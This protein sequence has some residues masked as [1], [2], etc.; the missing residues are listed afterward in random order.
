MS[1][2]FVR[3]MRQLQNGMMRVTGEFFDLNV[4]SL[5]AFVW[6]FYWRWAAG[7][8]LAY[9]GHA[10]WRVGLINPD[11][12]SNNDDTRHRNDEKKERKQNG[13]YQ[14]ETGPRKAVYAN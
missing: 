5:A 2:F 14:K 9:V 11:I 12:I 13:T 4:R 8:V 1:E 6:G 3:S 7:V 10:L